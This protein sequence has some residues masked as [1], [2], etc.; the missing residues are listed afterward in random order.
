MLS[1]W[2]A[3]SAAVVQCASHDLAVACTQGTVTSLC[4]TRPSYMPWSCC[5]C[6]SKE[7]RYALAFVSDV[8]QVSSEYHPLSRNIF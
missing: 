1:L 5:W 4:D 6:R 8:V 3:L 7:V 2:Q